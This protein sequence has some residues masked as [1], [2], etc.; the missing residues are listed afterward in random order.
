MKLQDLS[1]KLLSERPIAFHPAL[2]SIGGGATEGLFMSQLLYWTGKGG[3]PDGWIFKSREEWTAETCLSRREQEGARAAWKRLGVLEEK[4][5]GMPLRLW[6]RI[7]QARLTELLSS[8][9]D[10]T[11][12]LVQSDQ[13]VGTK[14]PT[15]LLTETTTETTSEIPSEHLNR[16]QTRTSPAPVADAAQDGE[17]ETIPKSP[18]PPKEEQNKTRSAVFEHF[19]RKTGLCP[20]P[21]NGQ[22]AKWRKEMGAL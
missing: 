21:T 22:T 16:A 6:Y 5:K 4:R 12:L 3:D 14:W 2:G 17:G 15:A 9:S 13:Q 8:W 7:N 1:L 11:G 10:M 18:G 20:P 19:K